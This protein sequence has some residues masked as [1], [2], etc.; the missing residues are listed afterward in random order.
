[1]KNRDQ[2]ISVSF[3]IP[4]WRIQLIQKKESLF[5]ESYTFFPHHASRSPC[6]KHVSCWS[7]GGCHSRVAL[8]AHWCTY[9]CASS[10]PNFPRIFQLFNIR[11][12]IFQLPYGNNRNAKAT[13]LWPKWL[14]QMLIILETQF[15][16]FSMWSPLFISEEYSLF[17]HLLRH[18]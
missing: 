7:W 9:I 8:T 2:L 10:L 16:L 17:G 11:W 15:H 1:M 4:H 18:L 12:E 5:Q 14:S 3:C 13:I 6:C